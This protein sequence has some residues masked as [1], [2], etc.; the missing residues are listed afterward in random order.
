MGAPKA[1]AAAGAAAT[2]FA[3]CQTMGAD[4]ISRRLVEI[5]HNRPNGPREVSPALRDG[6]L[7]RFGREPDGGCRCQPNID[8]DRFGREPTVPLTVLFEADFLRAGQGFNRRSRFTARET[9][10]SAGTGFPSMM[11]TT[12]FTRSRVRSEMSGEAGPDTSE[13]RSRVRMASASDVPGM[14]PPS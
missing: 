6:L 10:S 12:T 1:V 3:V 5:A 4:T 7:D 13:P 2:L 9:D 11:Q 14:K 8:E